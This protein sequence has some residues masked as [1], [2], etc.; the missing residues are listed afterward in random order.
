MQ[1]LPRDITC[2]T[3]FHCLSAKS[4]YYLSSVIC[5]NDHNHNRLLHSHL[6]YSQGLVNQDVTAPFARLAPV[7]T[8]KEFVLP[9]GHQHG[10]GEQYAEIDGVGMILFNTY[11]H[12][13]YGYCSYK[14][15]WLSGVVIGQP[16]D[17]VLYQAGCW[18]RGKKV[19][20]GYM[21]CS[22]SRKLTVVPR[23]NLFV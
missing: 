4:L 13:S 15:L 2:S 14:S 7:L 5:P 21:L 20:P 19:A 11:M 9:S 12:W 16:N 17:S 6:T 23:Q 18:S 10:P 8:V 22:N 1:S 3:F